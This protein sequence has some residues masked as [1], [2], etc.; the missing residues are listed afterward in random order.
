MRAATA[1]NHDFMRPVVEPAGHK[2]VQMRQRHTGLDSA[3]VGL[4]LVFILISALAAYLEPDVRVLHL[5]E[6]L[7]YV[8][9]IV[10]ALKHNKW[11]YGIGISAA[12]FWVG[13][14]LF[15][16][17]FLRDGIENWI[18]FLKTGRVTSA[19]A[20]VAVPAAI[21]QLLLIVCC[22][23]AYRRMKNKRWSDLEIL[24]GSALI[25]VVYLAGVVALFWPRFQLR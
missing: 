11:G 18:G 21:S 17:T 6:W 1:K 16:T 25:S 23:W 9:V 19:M 10:L 8:A 7:I 14:S 22:I 24:V 15:A 20:L 2:T 5:Y 4:C 3:I 13:V 12:T